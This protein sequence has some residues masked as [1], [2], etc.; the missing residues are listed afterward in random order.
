[1]ALSGTAT[2]Q[3]WETFRAGGG[4]GLIR[5]AVEMV[6]QEMIEA[7]AAEAI[8]AGRNGAT[9]SR[10]SGITRPISLVLASRPIGPVVASWCDSP[11]RKMKNAEIS[12]T[13]V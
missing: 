12:F 13:F 5:E 11:Q 6:L 8:G 9:W 3:L 1:M 2:A 10:Q 4:A 7:E